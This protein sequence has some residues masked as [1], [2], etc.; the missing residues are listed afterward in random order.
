MRYFSVVGTIIIKDTY[1]KLLVPV[2]RSNMLTVLDMYKI[3]VEEA[4]Q[5]QYIEHPL[6]DKFFIIEFTSFYEFANKEDWVLFFSER[7]GKTLVQYFMNMYG[8]YV[9]KNKTNKLINWYD[10]IIKKLCKKN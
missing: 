7:E 6:Q 2:Q 1:E 5:R 8:K 4:V 3:L 9:P 10:K